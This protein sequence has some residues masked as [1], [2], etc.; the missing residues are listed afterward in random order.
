MFLTMVWDFAQTVSNSDAIVLVQLS[1]LMLFLTIMLA[2]RIQSR[3]PFASMKKTMVRFQI[4]HLSAQFFALNIILGIL[5]K[6]TEYRNGKVAVARSR[7]LILS[8]IVT[9]VN[10]EYCLY[11]SFHQDGTIKFEIKATGEL[12]TNLTNAESCSEL[13]HG[14]LVAPNVEAQFHQHVFVARIDPMI[15]GLR[16]TVAN[17]DV[18]PIPEKI[19]SPANPYGQGFKLV[20]TPLK[21]TSEG[22]VDVSPSTSRVW[23]IFNPAFMNKINQKA[24]A[25]TLI[26]AN[27]C[28][29]MA[30][31][32]SYISKKAGFA[33]NSLWVTPYSEKEK[34]PSGFYV[35][36]KGSATNGINQWVK[37]EKN[38]ENEDVVLWHVFG[39]THCPR[40]ED[41]PI[42]SVE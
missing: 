10:Y 7:R 16:N 33:K 20:E 35:L 32:D 21:T 34:F 37:E 41:Y 30:S 22:Q 29:L 6:H 23:K 28:K 25:Y 39:M 36:N 4:R 12:S 31:P 11:W 2:N 9:V 18:R 27:P 3:M 17:L 42:M 5:F 1:T 15:D 40:I 24:V 14:I 8:F 38:I 26:P 19:G 13:N